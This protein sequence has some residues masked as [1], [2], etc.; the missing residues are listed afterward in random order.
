MGI[1]DGVQFQSETV[2]LDGQTFERCTFNHCV[3]IY[4][5]N[6]PPNFIQNSFAGNCEWRFGDAAG[7]TLNFLRH[8]YRGGFSA[9]V[10]KTFDNITS[11]VPPTS[12]G[13]S[14]LH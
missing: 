12:N 5:G 8:L 14:I 9:L 11:A 4:R 10:Q 7:R 6:E 2:E 13:P 3:L 1:H